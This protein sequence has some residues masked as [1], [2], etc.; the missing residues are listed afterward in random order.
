MGER[1]T[2]FG[3][4]RRT[5]TAGWRLILRSHSHIASAS[6]CLGKS[7]VS[8]DTL[9]QARGN[10]DHRLRRRFGQ[11]AIYEEREAILLQLGAYGYPSYGY[12]QHGKS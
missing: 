10:L 11:P 8:A 12:L 7:G 5:W 4:P 6:K 3:G 1:E 9:D 2:C